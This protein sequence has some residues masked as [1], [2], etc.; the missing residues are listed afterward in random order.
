MLDLAKLLHDAIGIES[1]RKFILVCALGG[2]VV[3]GFIGWLIDKG[4][5]QNWQRNPNRLQ[6]S[7]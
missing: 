4:I 1:P 7:I 3:F 5:E 2:F 6:L